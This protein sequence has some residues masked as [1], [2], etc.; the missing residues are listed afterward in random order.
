MET[1]TNRAFQVPKKSSKKKWFFLGLG[2]VSTGILSFFGYQYWKK[3]KKTSAAQD[4]KAPDFKAPQSKPATKPK[5]KPKAKPTAAA[6]AN[7]PPASA[8]KPTIKATALATGF[9][10]AIVSKTFNNVQKFLKQLKS[11][12]DYKAVNEAFSRYKVRGVTQTLVNALLSTFTLPAQ[13]D[14][15]RKAL[16]AAGLKYDGKKWSLSGL[17]NPPLLITT[18]PTEVWK[19]PKTSVPVPLNMVL[20]KEIAKRGSFTVFESDKQLFLVKSTHV[21]TYNTTN[22]KTP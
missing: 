11:P 21:K 2:L 14:A 6:A 7:K 19:D 15:I 4:Q 17:E 9:Y 20:G 13:K 16:T 1:N 22:Q 12:A 18:Q 5:T 10:A 8:P 3:H